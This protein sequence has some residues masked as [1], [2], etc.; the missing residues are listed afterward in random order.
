MSGD[1][2]DYPYPPSMPP[3]PPS[4]YSRG[5]GGMYPPQGGSRGGWGPPDPY[6]DQY[7]DPNQSPNPFAMG[8]DYFPGGQRAS[9]GRRRPMSHHPPSDSMALTMQHGGAFSPW[10][11]PP[12]FPYHGYPQPP[13]HPSPSPQNNS[14]KSTPPPAEEPKQITDPRVDAIHAMLMDSRKR[15][16]QRQQ[17]E[18]NRRIEEERAKKMHALKEEEDKLKRL[19][20]LIMKH[21]NDQLE[22]EKKQEALRKAEEMA[23]KELE[24]ATLE[25]KK[26]A[27]EKAKEVKQAAELAKLEAEKEAAKKAA[28]EKE[29]HEKELDEIKKKAAEHEAA[30]KKFEEE[31]KKLRPGDDMLKPPIRFKDAVGRKFS[32]PWHICKDWKVSCCD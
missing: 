20:I 17:Q 1:D 14:K 3:Y 23:K 30:K 32:F 28:E 9:S 15:E 7:L 26:V 29:K 24:L 31:A 5:F 16:E 8:G 19:E 12:G 21:N 27:D 13:F 4:D 6:I 10:G 11:Y 25:A 18:L 22:R 2:D